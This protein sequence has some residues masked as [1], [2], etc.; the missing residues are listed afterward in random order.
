MQE[1][2]QQNYLTSFLFESA[3]LR[4]I[5]H[6]SAI[7]LWIENVNIIRELYPLYQNSCSLDHENL[8]N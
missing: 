3:L 7:K 6:T 5:S 4:C 2:Q 1:G 8:F